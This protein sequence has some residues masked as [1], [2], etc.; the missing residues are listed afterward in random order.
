MEDEWSIPN[1]DIEKTSYTVQEFVE[2]A[3]AR[4]LQLSPKFQ[5]G[6][7]WKRPA[8]AF[9]IDTILRGFPV[10]PVHLRF[11]RQADGMLIREVID[12]QQRLTAVLSYIAGDYALPKPRKSSEPLPPWSGLR[13]PALSPDLQRR[14]LDF[15]FRCE[16][17]KAQIADQTVHEI[18]ARINIHSIPLSDQELRNGRYFGEFKQSVYRLAREH[19][20]FWKSCGLFSEQSIARMLDAQFVS[21][22]LVAHL[23]GMQ[24]KK[25][26]LETFYAQLDDTW[27]E[28]ELN[29]DRFREV[30]DSIRDS[31]GDIISQTKFKRIPL[32]YTL[33][34]VI[35]H[36]LY[37]L[38][39]SIIP[40]GESLPS[41][42]LKPLTPE[43]KLR[44]RSTVQAISDYLTDNDVAEYDD[45]EESLKQENETGAL[46]EF[47]DGAASQTDNLRPRIAR[48]NSFWKL[49]NF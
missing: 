9:L 4:R 42:P 23:D 12:G 39:Q 16:V 18:F 33:Y 15:S 46:A 45:N 35:Y 20:E 43:L 36:R 19:E 30:I 26:S 24:D 32:F 29:E 38:S 31:V 11:T 41:S 1:L 25:G 17:Y 6:Q 28:R 14:I 5:R 49:A 2:W 37:G 34:I 21:E 8:Q 47:A 7:V 13:F 40:I 48:F 3:E 27:P 44:I 10:P 22:V